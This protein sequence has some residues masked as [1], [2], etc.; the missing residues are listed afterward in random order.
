M[1]HL[2]YRF[3]DILIRQ[4][5]PGDIIKPCLVFSNL[6]LNQEK[7]KKTKTKQTKQ[8]NKT[9]IFFSPVALSLLP[10]DIQF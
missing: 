5:D 6:K 7:K 9:L 4:T 10:Y 3:V 2:L 8:T 1:S